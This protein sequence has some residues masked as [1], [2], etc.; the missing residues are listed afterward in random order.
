MLLVTASLTAVLMSLISSSVGSSWAAKQA[1]AVRASIREAADMHPIGTNG[2]NRS[3]RCS[4]LGRVLCQEFGVERIA[5]LPA[6]D[7]GRILRRASCLDRFPRVLGP[8]EMELRLAGVDLDSAFR[9]LQEARASI[10]GYRH[11]VHDVLLAPLTSLLRPEGG[12]QAAVARE[13][14]SFMVTSHLYDAEQAIRDVYERLA[15]LTRDMPVLARAFD[16]GAGA[17]AMSGAE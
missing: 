1:A 4:A 3:A 2:L 5:D 14:V 8:A 7:F 13:T 10:A 17:P 11:A 15:L 16:D 9:A 12:T 6:R